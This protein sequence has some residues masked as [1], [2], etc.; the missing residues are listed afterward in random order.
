MFKYGDSSSRQKID[1]CFYQKMQNV[2]WFWFQRFYFKANKKTFFLLKKVLGI[3]KVALHLKDW[4]V[5]M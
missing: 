5:F 4:D 2:R 1:G 3:F